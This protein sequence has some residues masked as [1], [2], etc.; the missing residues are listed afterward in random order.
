[1]P[2]KATDILGH[3]HKVIMLVLD[4]AEKEAN[5][6]QQSG[7]IH[8][9]VVTKILEVLRNFAD[10]CHYGKEEKH[11]FITMQKRGM[12]ADSGPIA[13]MLLEHAEGRKYIKTIADALPG[14]QAGDTKAVATL[15]DGLVGYV[16]LLRAHITK[17]NNILFPMAD[18]MFTE[19]DQK[20]LI[21]A[22]EQIEREEMGAGVHEKY[23]RWAH[24]LAGK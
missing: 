14:A 3:E 4:A 17:E 20:D 22:F 8:A 11:L 5:S 6:I 23:H 9:D 10:K 21:K 2:M 13:V 7:K 12:P 16:A 1:M 19:D 15:R 24:E 18:Q